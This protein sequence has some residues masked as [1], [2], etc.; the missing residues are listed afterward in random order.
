MFGDIYRSRAANREPY[1]ILNDEDDPWPET[2]F[3]LVES[4]P[5]LDGMIPINEFL[6]AHRP[7]CAVPIKQV[8][9]HMPFQDGR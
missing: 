1:L 8:Y 4:H 7:V 6:K 5:D 2:I 3:Y 9:K